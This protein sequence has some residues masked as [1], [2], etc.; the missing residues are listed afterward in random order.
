MDIFVKE[1]IGAARSYVW[2]EE[3]KNG[4]VLRTKWVACVDQRS[5]IC[6]HPSPVNKPALF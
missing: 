3:R 5:T 1:A 4:L 6:F 2:L